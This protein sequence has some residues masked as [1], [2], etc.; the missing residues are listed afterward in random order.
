MKKK[1]VELDVDF[2]GGQE[3]LTKEEALALRAYF[4]Q[5]TN[6]PNKISTIIPQVKKNK[7]K[8]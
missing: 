5:K 2:I 8:A 3:K 6:V 4:A 7:V 1:T